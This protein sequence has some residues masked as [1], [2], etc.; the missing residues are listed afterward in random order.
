M[1]HL[2]PLHLPLSAWKALTWAALLTSFK[3]LLH[4]LTSEVPLTVTLKTETHP[5][6][7]NPPESFPCTNYCLT[8]HVINYFLR[9]LFIFCLNVRIY[10]K[11]EILIQLADWMDW[12]I[13]LIW[14]VVMFCMIRNSIFHKPTSEPF[15]TCAEKHICLELEETQKIFN[16]LHRQVGN[17]ALRDNFPTFIWSANGKGTQPWFFIPYSSHVLERQSKSRKKEQ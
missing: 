6:T 14:E 5:H 2:R 11:A 1:G 8:Y 4:C 7:P 17:Q 10:V 15:R 3:W 12:V 16:Y 9:L 13:I